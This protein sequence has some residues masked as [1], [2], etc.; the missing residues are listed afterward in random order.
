[1]IVG[2]A[3]ETSRTL[4][5][6]T[7]ELERARLALVERERLASL[8]ELAAVVAH[9]VRNPLA[10]VFNALAGLRRFPRQDPDEVVLLGIIEQE[11]NRLKRLVAT[12]L[13]AVRPFE[14]QVGPH[15]LSV[16]VDN[17]VALATRRD[18]RDRAD[19]TV[20][21]DAP[22]GATF[23]CDDVLLTQALS[24]LVS[25]ALDAP[26]RSAPVRV[27]V[28]APANPGGVRFEVIDDGEGVAEADRERIFT[29]FFTTRATGTGLGLALVKRIAEAHQGFVALEASPPRGARFV[30][31]LPAPLGATPGPHRARTEFT[32]R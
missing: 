32:A 10:I 16:I 1:V 4:S 29:P 24:N 28:T 30:I 22:E 7:S 31:E 26:G 3:I 25:N 27:R 14:L 18:E 11:A 9:E 19:V 5:A 15:A 23:P 6:K 17:S 13:D 20:D 21:V 2:G 12:L 8:G